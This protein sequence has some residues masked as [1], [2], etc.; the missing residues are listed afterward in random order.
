MNQS[1]QTNAESPKGEVARLLAA[2]RSQG[3]Q[4]TYGG[5]RNDTR[6]SDG[7]LLEFTT[8]LK[9]PKLTAPTS[10]H[11]MSENGCAF[12]ARKKVRPR[13]LVYL[14]EPSEDGKNPWI[15]AHVTHCTVGIRGF[16]VGVKF[17]AE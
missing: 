9:K 16:L 4:D 5:K 14:R 7:F 11:N 15:Q 2:V 10:L 1:T 13:T 3:S 6:F 17:E 8:D 12:W